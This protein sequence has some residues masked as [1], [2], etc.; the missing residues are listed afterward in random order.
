MQSKIA[1]V[2]IARNEE[3]L[4][5]KT[6]DSLRNQDLRPYRII[7]VNDGSTD[8][9]EE[10][11]SAYNEVEIV[12]R[13]NK[14]TYEPEKLELAEIINT[15]LS[16]LKD[17]KDCMFIV[18][19]DADI[20]LPKN[21]L[22]TINERM[23]SNPKIAVS[24]GIIEGEFST[25]PRGAGRVV[26]Y[27]FWK[28]IGLSYPVNHG[29]EGYLLLKARSMGY[30]DIVF[31]DLVMQTGRK[32]G[33]TYTDPKRYYNYGLA[34]K[35]QGQ[36]LPEVLIRSLKLTK[37]EP[38]SAFYLLKGFFSNYNNLY[39]SELREYVKKMQYE[40]LKKTRFKRTLNSLKINIFR[41]RNHK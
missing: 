32:T 38:R 30:E 3:K 22:S 26:R 2:I 25:A 20:I 4:I 1:V 12:N 39:E 21:Y 11:V 24:S 5:A 27:D 14:G 41:W 6:L 28:K 17:D 34:M 7:L 40:E 23:N 29:Y 9:T 36:I 31:R 35:A 13:K 10:I 16:K 18:K 19:L 33:S 37:K 8:R 15:G